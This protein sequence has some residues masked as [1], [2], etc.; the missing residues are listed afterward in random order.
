MIV[1]E[2]DSSAA[3]G[4]DIDVRQISETVSPA[5]VNIAATLSNRNQTAGSGVVITEGGLVITNNHVI[6]GATDIEVEVGVTEE[7]YSAK[8]LGYDVEDDIAL[9]ELEDA[10]DMQTIRTADSSTVSRNDAVVA[11]GNALGRMGEPSVVAGTVTALHQSITAGDGVDRE[12]LEDMIRIAASI[13]PGDSGG[14]LVNADGRVIG[15]NTAADAGA[16]RYG[17]R[18][19]TVGFA[20]PIEKAL[21]I[22]NQIRTG[23]SSNGVHIGDRA[24]L[25]V[26]LA[27]AGEG[28]GRLDGATVTDVGSNTPAEDAGIETGDTIT[29][30]DGEPVGSGEE[31][32]TLL[33]RYHPGDR[34]RVTWTDTDGQ[35]RRA[36]VT[37][38]KGP[39]A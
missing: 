16:G 13:Q 27:G 7:S 25:G 9:L 28:F 26:V 30:L 6:N 12:S 31:L 3:T 35:R 34:V 19:G 4:L 21:E 1:P 23:D 37:L 17:Y 2:F 32:R 39:P 5:V 36:T 8:V 14:A 18:A 11:I 33:H 15:I 38:I 24:L 22:A 10:S 29:A 20:I